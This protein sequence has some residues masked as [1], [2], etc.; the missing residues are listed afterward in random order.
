VAKPGGNLP[1]GSGD[2]LVVVSRHGQK[3][4]N[5]SVFGG[6]IVTPGVDNHAE[7]RSNDVMLRGHQRILRGLEKDLDRMPARAASH[8]P[9]LPAK[10]FNLLG[11]VETLDIEGSRIGRTPDPLL[12][13]GSGGTITAHLAVIRISF[14]RESDWRPLDLTGRSW[15]FKAPF[16]IVL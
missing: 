9:D 7:Q 11:A 8:R 16:T 3:E 5:G 4:R 14:F 1:T 6:L 12:L 2:V 15:C 13:S 10:R